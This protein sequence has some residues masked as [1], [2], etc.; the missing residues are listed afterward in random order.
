MSTMQGQASPAYRNYVLGVL[1]VVYTFNFIDRQILGILKDAIREELHLTDGELGLMG[2]LAFAVLYSTLGLPIAWLADRKSRTGIMTVALVVWSGFSAACGLAGS[3]TSLFLMRMGVGIG[4]AGGVAPA[5]SLISD[6]FPPEQRGRALSVYS[7]GIPIG[8]ALGILFGGLLSAELGWRA[9]FFWVGGAGLLVA[10]VLKLTVRDPVRGGN[11]GK[12]GA[13]AASFGEVARLLLVKPSFWLLAL[14][15]ASSSV[16]GYGVAFWLPTF[17]QRSLGLTL[18]ETSWYYGTITLVGGILGIFLGGALA[19]RFGALKRSAYA[20]V[21]AACFLI[22]MPCFYLALWSSSLW[23]AFPLFLIPTGLNLAWLGPVITAVQ[24]LV[25]PTMRSTASALFL[26]VNNLVGIALGTYYFGFVSDLLQPRFGD[27]SIRWAI[28][29]GG[30]FWMLAAILLL[31][32]SRK[33]DTDWVDAA[34]A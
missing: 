1:V 34:K 31:V 13:A 14:G 22:A 21:P 16:C 27:E 20:L 3:F 32:A 23:V 29:S 17:F 28:Y 15:A 4:E 9:T 24:H 6:Y 8:M 26:L 2:G 19:D 18:V 12:A 25:P 7:F 30:A 33:L 11:D 10:P 5:Y